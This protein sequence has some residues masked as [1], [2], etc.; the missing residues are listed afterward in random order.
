M[1]GRTSAGFT[2]LEVIVALAVFGLLLVGLSQTVGF[3][4]T[5]WRESAASDN[6]SDIESLDRG[7]RLI[8]QNLA[9]GDDAGQPPIAGD[10]TALTGRTRM[11]VP[12][13]GLDEVPVEA[14]L[15]V[16]GNR[17]VLRWRPYHHGVALGPPPRPQEVD[18]MTGV[19]R[20]AIAYWRPAGT[21][22]SSWH[23][24]DLPLLIRL[25]VTLIGDNAPHW[26][27]LVVAPRLSRP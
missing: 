3:G 20:L 15:A 11:R 12:G 5:A 21:W 24:P 26:P 2:L 23:E 7:L 17:L 9:P 13:S 18:L 8:I 16:S 22:T 6:K 4:L 27:D 1:S 19:G 10:A 14:G 25:R